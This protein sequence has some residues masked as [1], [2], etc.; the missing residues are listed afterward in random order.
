MQATPLG[1]KKD[2]GSFLDTLFLILI[3]KNGDSSLQEWRLIIWPK[4]II[5]MMLPSLPAWRKLVI[6]LLCLY[7]KPF[8]IMSPF[9][10]QKL[11]WFTLITTFRSLFQSPKKYERN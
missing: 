11:S 1:L 6:P 5:N 3:P 4:D 7:R 10:D 8:K 2:E 9:V